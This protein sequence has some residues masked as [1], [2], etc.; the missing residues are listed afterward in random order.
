MLF[1]S[2]Y[3]EVAITGWKRMDDWLRNSPEMEQPDWVLLPV[4]FYYICKDPSRWSDS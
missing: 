3:E 2:L 4:R 1:R